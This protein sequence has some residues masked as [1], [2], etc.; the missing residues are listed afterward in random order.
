MNKTTV[1][2]RWALAAMIAAASPAG[3]QP[4]VFE[5]L[6]RLEAHIGDFAGPH[7]APRVDRR[8]KLGA[9]A[10]RPELVWYGAGQTTVLVRCGAP[11]GWQI[12]VPVDMKPAGQG[13]V[14]DG[15][16]AVVVVRPVPRGGTITAGDVDFRPD[17]YVPG[18]ATAIDQVVGKVVIRALSPGETV[19]TNV[20][21]APNAVKRGDP[22]QIRSGGTG[23][24]VAVEGVAEQDAPVGGRVRV[25][26]R[27]VASGSRIQ[28]IVVSPGIVALPGY[29]NPETGRE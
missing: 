8:L 2:R 16:G 25:R 7:R 19:R 21:I 29:K 10:M 1:S 24:E 20:V 5:N 15:S 3:A 22:V 17:T 28:T 18:G 4:V 12:Y 13:A 23:I 27:N 26:V 11:D 6:D 9:C 14:Q